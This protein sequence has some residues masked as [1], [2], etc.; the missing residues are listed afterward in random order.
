MIKT[1]RNP[2]R[3][4]W[5]LKRAR[6]VNLPSPKDLLVQSKSNPRTSHQ[7]KRRRS[8]SHRNPKSQNKARI[9]PAASHLCQVIT[10][11]MRTSSPLCKRTNNSSN[12]RR[13]TTPQSL[14]TEPCPLTTI[15]FY[16]LP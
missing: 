10:R 1:S 9:I 8:P 13:E 14:L 4:M 12:K 5:K 2:T 7:R 15:D 3:I 6:R 11:K 16:Q